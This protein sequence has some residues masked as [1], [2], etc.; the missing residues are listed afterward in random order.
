MFECESRPRTFLD[1]KPKISE[2]TI[3]SVC[4]NVT[5]MASPTHKTLT[6]E[7][8]IAAYLHRTRMEILSAL[9]NGPSTATQIARRLGVHPA[10]LTRHIR[11]LQNAGLVELDHTRDTGRN[12]E[13]YYRSVADSYG[14]A[15]DAVSLASPHKIALSFARS[16]L[17]GAIA[18]VPEHTERPVLALVAAARVTERDL[19]EF[20]RRLQDL[21]EE[22]ESRDAQGACEY[23]MNLS[24]YP[25]EF[26]TDE[27]AIR[28]SK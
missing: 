6:N 9:H 11:I 26:S 10:N 25:G 24:L 5:R 7:E 21:V 28:V 8:Q 23:H 2:L 12:L 20:C 14:V 22:F 18:H 17:S 27:G 4:A 1:D 15:P 13:K 16:D 19:E 3:V